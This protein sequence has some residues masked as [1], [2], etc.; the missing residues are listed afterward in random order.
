MGGGGVKTGMA[1]GTSNERAEVPKDRPIRVEDVAA[2]IY[3]ALGVD[4]EKEYMSP[5][6]RPLKINYDGEPIKELL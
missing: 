1:V 6:N 2:T 3:K 5:Q 4:Y